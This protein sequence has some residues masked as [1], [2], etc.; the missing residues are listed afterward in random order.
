[1]KSG[2][3]VLKYA[4]TTGK[5]REMFPGSPKSTLQG[6]EAATTGTVGGYRPD[7]LGGRSLP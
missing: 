2:D 1:M 3:D 4:L 7:R 6:A 5:L